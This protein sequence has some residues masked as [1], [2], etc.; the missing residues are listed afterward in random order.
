MKIG[1]I[2]TGGT[3]TDRAQSMLRQVKTIAARASV[4]R[5]YID[6]GASGKDITR[7]QLNAMLDNVSAGDTI[8]ISDY[9]R[10]DR[11]TIRLTILLEKLNEMDATVVMSDGYTP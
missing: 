11:D 10:L 3:E 7:S 2:R 5:L 9:A 4:D 1:Y 6:Y 8:Y